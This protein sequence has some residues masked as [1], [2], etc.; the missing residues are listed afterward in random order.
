MTFATSDRMNALASENGGELVSHQSLN[1]GDRFL[2]FADGGVRLC[3]TIFVHDELKGVARVHE[4]AT[5]RQHL[6]TGEFPVVRLP[7]LVPIYGSAEAIWD[8]ERE[9]K[10]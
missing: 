7:P 3:P 5:H 1:P 4:E 10:D 9:Y 8:G 2:I 6:M